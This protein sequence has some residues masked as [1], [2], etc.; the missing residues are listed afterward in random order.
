[1]YFQVEIVTFIETNAEVNQVLLEEMVIK[2]ML[3]L[4]AEDNRHCRRS[5]KC[6]FAGQVNLCN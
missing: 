1:V 3:S 4:G 6:C 2:I 5:E